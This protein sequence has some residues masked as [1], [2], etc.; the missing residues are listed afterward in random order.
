[1]DTYTPPDFWVT[2]KWKRGELHDKRVEFELTGPDKK[3]GG[4]G[5]FRIAQRPSGEQH[6]DIVVTTAP[7]YWERID[8]IFTLKQ[9]HADRIRSHPDASVAEFRCLA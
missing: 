4:I 9:A 3:V 7:S 8:H 6:I 1:M 5:V 2:T